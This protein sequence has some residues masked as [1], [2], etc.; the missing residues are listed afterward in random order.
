MN[1]DKT[2]I[3]FN[4]D[5]MMN[6]LNE[7]TPKTFNELVLEKAAKNIKNWI[8]RNPNHKFPKSINSWQRLLE[9]QFETII[10]KVNPN[11]ILNTDIDLNKIHYQLDELKKKIIRFMNKEKNRDLLHNNKPK[12][13]K[14]VACFSRFK[15]KVNSLELVNKLIQLNIIDKKTECIS[16]N[17]KRK[18]A[19]L[20]D[21]FSLDNDDDCIE[22]EISSLNNVKKIKMDFKR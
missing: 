22:L 7:I 6:C 11:T 12:L 4:M 8:K 2:T 16:Q 9:S 20:E 15:Y 3:V 18:R 19:E 1:Y 14:I 10:V 17:N 21:T 13:M 5:S